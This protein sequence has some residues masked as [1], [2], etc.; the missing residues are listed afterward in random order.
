MI[1]INPFSLLFTVHG[2][3]EVYINYIVSIAAVSN[4][5]YVPQYSYK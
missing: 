1:S 4:I 2:N 3:V 5:M